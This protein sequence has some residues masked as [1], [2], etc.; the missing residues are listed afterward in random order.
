[1]RYKKTV[2]QTMT[3]ITQLGISILVPI[4]MCVFIGSYLEDRFQFP[5]FIIFLVMGILAGCKNVYKIVMKFIA[6]SAADDS[7][8]SS[9]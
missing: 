7:R 2:F 4:F 3:L 8:D 6:I 9:V 1:M 5:F